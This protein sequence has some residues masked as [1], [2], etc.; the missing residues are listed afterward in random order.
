MITYNHDL[1]LITLNNGSISYCIYINSAGY[2]QK[3]YFGKALNNHED[4]SE[5][6]N[7]KYLTSP[8]YDVTKGEEFLYADGYKSDLASL[9]LHS[10]GLGDK[11]YSAIIIK[12]ENGSLETD[13]KY[14]SHQIYSGIKPLKSPM[15]YAKGENCETVEILMKDGFT[16]L[17]LKQYITIYSDKDIIVKSFE[18]INPTQ[19][20]VS[21]TRA[22]SMQLG[23][24]HTAY[25]MVHYGGR[26][27]NER[28]E[29][30]N[31]LHD[32]TQE[33][34]SNHGKSSHYE[35]P[36]VYLKEVGASNEYGE[37][38][39]FNLIY[40]GN[41]KFRVDCDHLGMASIC[42]GMNDED[43]E[44]NIL[45]NESFTLPQAVIS[46]S[47]N[48]VDKM[49]QNFH[50]FIRENLIDYKHDK[51]YKPVLFNSWEGC[52]FDFN[53]QTI[54]DYIDDACK[55]GTEL[56]VLDDG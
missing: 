33:V 42:Y 45:P 1:K 31:R 13:F 48:G 24:N 43:F 14:V 20:A 3:V 6:I 44:W 40:S 18:V 32:G 4:F 34:S 37:V 5:I 54:I 22:M 11:K 53:T 35:N 49:S 21:L 23:L 7:A 30:V 46:Y 38:I 10:H 51:E 16:N 29:M 15:P 41:F 27:L 39:G 55:I 52:V 9:E 56:F 26:W 17:N 8:Y 19:N 50:K 36:F 12:G 28:A 25:D 2:L 47:Y